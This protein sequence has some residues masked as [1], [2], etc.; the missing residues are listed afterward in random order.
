MFRRVNSTFW[1][2]E[3]TKKELLKMT[4]Y[5]TLMYSTGTK[6]RAFLVDL[7][8]I[9]LGVQKGQLNFLGTPK[10]QKRTF[11]DD[12]ISD[13]DILYSYYKLGFFG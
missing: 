7:R 2:H 10:D 3:M 9:L 4:G 11:K 1:G 8:S 5:Q 6:N 13:P 12:W